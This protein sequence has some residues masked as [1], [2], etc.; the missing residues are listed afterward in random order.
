M[1]AIIIATLINILAGISVAVDQITDLEKGKDWSIHTEL[2]FVKTAGNTDTETISLKFD[3][4]NKGI[5]NKFFVKGSGLYAKTDEKESAA[6]LDLKG[7]WER[8]FTERFFSFLTTGFLTDKFSGYEYRINGG[9]GI[10]YYLLYSERYELKILTSILFY[11]DRE[12]NPPFKEDS[13]TSSEIETF[14]KFEILENLSFKS[15][16]SYSISL[17]E[18][19]KYFITGDA[20]IE[21]SINSYISMGVGYQIYYQNKLPD[22]SVKRLDTTFLTSLIIDI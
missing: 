21:V 18:P 22:P 11:K 12:F 2:S 7:R 14:F 10:G 20:S 8:M 5:E 15:Y 4:S 9:P 19:E 6:R 1:K 3:I 13:Y 16:L 17:N